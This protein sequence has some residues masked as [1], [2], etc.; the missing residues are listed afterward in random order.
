MTRR[1]AVIG[2]CLLVL[3]TTAGLAISFSQKSSQRPARAAKQPTSSTATKPTSPKPILHSLVPSEPTQ[4][5]IPALG[6]TSSVESVGQTKTGDMESPKARNVTGWYKFGYLPGSLGNSVIAGHS[7]HVQGRGVFASL[8]KLT[9]GDHLKL[10]TRSSMQTY[11][12]TGTKTLPNDH[13]LTDDIFG[14]SD[15]ARLNLITCTGAWDKQTQRYADRLVVF[16]EFV[17]E[18]TTESP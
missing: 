15:K 16:S 13:T 6:I 8:G 4:L 18:K 12:V 11:A 2:T 17:S 14:P 10:T 1:R 3:F 5:A 7:W 9:V